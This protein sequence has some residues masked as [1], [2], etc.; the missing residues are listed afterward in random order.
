MEYSVW[1][2]INIP[3]QKDNPTGMQ[4]I[5]ANGE[6]RFGRALKQLNPLTSYQQGKEMAPITVGIHRPYRCSS[7][8]FSSISPHLTRP[9]PRY[10]R[11]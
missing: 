2:E 7:V 8:S 5:S 6:E 9:N 1:A 11:M 4:G 10:A 3:Q